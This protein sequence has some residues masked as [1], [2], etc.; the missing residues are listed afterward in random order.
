M[1]T[2]K[3]HSAALN[4]SAHMMLAGCP[5]FRGRIWDIDLQQTLDIP[6]ICGGFFL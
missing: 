5:G 2:R 3:M 6:P 1:E 4:V